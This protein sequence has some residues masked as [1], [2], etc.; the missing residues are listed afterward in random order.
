MK[1]VV[2]KS[3]KAM[4]REKDIFT[5]FDVNMHADPKR[6]DA[7]FMLLS[8]QLREQTLPEISVAEINIEYNDIV[9]LKFVANNFCWSKMV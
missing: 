6:T 3:E 4:V 9:Y 7:D 5:R 2:E 1:H 8:A